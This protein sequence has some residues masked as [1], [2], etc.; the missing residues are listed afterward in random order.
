MHIVFYTS[1][2]FFSFVLAVIRGIFLHVSEFLRWQLAASLYD[3]LS[4][5]QNSVPFSLGKYMLGFFLR[6]LIVCFST[7]VRL[8]HFF[9]GFI[10]FKIDWKPWCIPLKG[11][12]YFDTAF[13]FLDIFRLWIYDSIWLL[14]A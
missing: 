6:V 2:I 7:V 3:T 8:D 13:R 1:L 10:C 12:F 5:T 4:I 9:L 11:A 14:V